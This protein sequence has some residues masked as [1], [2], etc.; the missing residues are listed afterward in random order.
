MSHAS[1]KRDI[2]ALAERQGWLVV[3]GDAMQGQLDLVICAGGRYYEVDVKV[4]RD[5][6]K[7]S[8]RARVRQVELAGGTAGEVRSIGDVLAKVNARRREVREA[9]AK[10]IYFALDKA[11]TDARESKDTGAGGLTSYADDA[12]DRVAERLELRNVDL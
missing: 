7:A 8:Q 12:A 1:L 11:E 6:L 4:G 10:E 9:L 3:S 2:R 5:R